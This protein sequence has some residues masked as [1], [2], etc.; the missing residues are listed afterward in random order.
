M[1]TDAHADLFRGQFR[2]I[3]STA[4]MHTDAHNNLWNYAAIFTERQR[5][6]QMHTLTYGIARPLS[7]HGKNA[8]GCTR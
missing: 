8:H 7:Q 5:F 1:H 2:S 4:E 3:H 6:T